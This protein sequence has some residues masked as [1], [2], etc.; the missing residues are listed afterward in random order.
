MAVARRMPQLRALLVGL[1]VLLAACEKAPRIQEISGPTMGTTWTVKYVPPNSAADAG[2]VREDIE[3]ALEAVNAQM[4]TYREDSHISRFNRAAAGESITVPPEFSDVLRASMQLAA[5]TGGAYDPTVGPL[6]NLWGFGPDGARAEPPAIEDI[7]AARARVGWQQL[8]LNPDTRT[9]TQRGGVYLDLSSIAKGYAVDLIAGRLEQRGTTAYLVDIGGDMR[10]RGRK[11][12]GQRWRIGIE[13]PG[14]GQRAVHSVIEPGDKA[15]ATSG[16]YRNFFRDQER[17]YSHTI[18]PRTGYP[19]PQDV[20][21]VTV[22]HDSCTQADGLATAITA[23]GAEAGYAFARDRDL[24]VLLLIRDNGTVRERMTPAFS[25]Y[26]D[27]E[28]D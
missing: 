13:R 21:S 19:I 1:C 28:A 27:G 17:E 26:L 6:V 11:P 4:S 8:G 22:L 9:L 3:A 24:A 20:V 23:L 14:P 18:D 16:S 2:R 12:D 7:K 10:V 5:Q 25:P 15:V